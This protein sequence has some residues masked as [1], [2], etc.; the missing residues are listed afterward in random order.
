[1]ATA[2]QAFLSQRAA[3]TAAEAE[4]D[5]DRAAFAGVQQE[6]QGGQRSQLD[7]LNAEQELIS[8]EIAA[9]S[10]RHDHVV[11]A[12]RLLSATGLLT[13]RSLNLQVKLYDPQLHYDDKAHAW[14]GFGD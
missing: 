5:A 13:A 6:R 8:A 9:A 1:M 2:W 11:A 4:A 3:L 14:I 7:V 12:Y 10:A